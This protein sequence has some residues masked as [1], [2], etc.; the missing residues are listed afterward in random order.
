M[1]KKIFIWVVLSLLLTNV[2]AFTVDLPNNIN[3]S[4]KITYIP[5]TITSDSG[6]FETIK[7]K[8]NLITNFDLVDEIE[9]KD[10]VEL[11]LKIYNSKNISGQTYPGEIVFESNNKKVEK[12]FN[13]IFQESNSNNSNSGFV[14]LANLPS[15]IDFFLAILLL[16]LIVAV[17]ARVKKRYFTKELNK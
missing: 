7:I 3:I 4:E 15:F 5:I 17:G 8:P 9:L 13:L 16:L 2:N 14:N 1:V 11:N 10:K 12:Q 6:L